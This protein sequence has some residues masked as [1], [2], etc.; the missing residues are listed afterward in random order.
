M[1]QYYITVQPTQEPITLDE[2]KN[3]LRVDND[4]E[5]DL[6][7]D[8]IVS[9][10]EK[11]ESLLWRPLLTQSW[12]LIFDSSELAYGGWYWQ[13]YFYPNQIIQVNKCPIQAIDSI[14][15]LDTNGVQQTLAPSNYI[16]DL[17]SEPARIQIINM[18]NIE[19]NAMNAFWVNF[20]AGYTDA[21]LIPRKI[22]NAMYMLLGHVYEHRETVTVGVTNTKLEMSVEYLIEEFRNNQ[23]IYINQ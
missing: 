15:Y 2:A 16:V 3:Y 10:R 6:I 23:Y 7:S 21:S 5:N 18:P 20:T 22:K 9:V 8:L 1:A 11:M 19:N 12:K 17:L 13:N 4:D 14:Q